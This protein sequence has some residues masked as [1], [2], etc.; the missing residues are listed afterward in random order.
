MGLDNGVD[1]AIGPEKQQAGGIGTPGTI[2]EPF[3]RGA[4]TPVQIFQHQHQRALGRQGIQGFG[5]FAQHPR[6]D[7]VAYCALQRLPLS[8]RHQRRHLHEPARRILPQHGHQTGA[9]RFSAEASERFQHGQIR[10]SRAIWLNTLPM[11]HA[12]LPCGGHLG[13]KGLHQRGLADP[14]LSG[15]DPDLSRALPCRGPPLG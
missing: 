4:I 5:Q 14:G 8:G 12:A 11:P 10:L 3:Q 15:D 2:G 6:L 1:G 9:I 13:K 7:G